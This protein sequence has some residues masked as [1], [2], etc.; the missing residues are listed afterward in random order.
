MAWVAICLLLL[1]PVLLHENVVNFE[2]R[3]L[4]ELFGT[5]YEIDELRMDPVA[6]GS[7]SRRTRMYRIL[8][9]KASVVS[10]LFPMSKLPEM[11]GRICH[12]TYSI[13]L[14]ASDDELLDEIKWARGR[15][16]SNAGQAEFV[17]VSRAQVDI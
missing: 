14:F 11:F 8:T 5:W 4:E 10:A 7:P 15:P 1:F 17:L 13:Y 9:H 12:A 3:V 6:F 2:R 16:G